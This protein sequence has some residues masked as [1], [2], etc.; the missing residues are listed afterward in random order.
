MCVAFLTVVANILHY[1]IAIPCI[2]G[3]HNATEKIKNGQVIT[4]DTTSGD[5]G[6]IYDGEVEFEVRM[7]VCVCVCVRGGGCG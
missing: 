1:A 2:V 3:C 6:L 4:V 5:D 7:C